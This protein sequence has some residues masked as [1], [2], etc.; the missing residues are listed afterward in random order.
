MVSVKLNVSGLLD[1]GTTNVGLANVGFFSAVPS[2]TA[3]SGSWVQANEDANIEPVP[4]SVTVDVGTTPSGSGPASATGAAF[5][6]STLIVYLSV[7][8]LLLPVAVI[9]TTYVPA[10]DALKVVLSPLAADSVAPVV[11]LTLHARGAVTVP[12]VPRPS[13][14][15]FWPTWT[16]LA[17]PLISATTP[18]A[19][20]SVPVMT[21]SSVSTPPLFEVT[22][23]SAGGTS[24]AG[25]VQVLTPFATDGVTAGTPSSFSAAVSSPDCAE[26][27]R[28]R[29]SLAYTE[30]RMCTL[31]PNM[32]RSMWSTLS[33]A[34]VVLVTERSAGGAPSAKTRA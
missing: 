22:S 5:A 13:R 34:S 17:S 8:L 2:C 7:L 1:G 10:T 25:M 20:S 19:W 24:R 9:D 27:V 3:S 32:A 12:V 29:V 33:G 16:V 4:S 26:T 31:S 28:V 14:V 21:T 11:G 15:T 30:L 23:T 18:T 6:P